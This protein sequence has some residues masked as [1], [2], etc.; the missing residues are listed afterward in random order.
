[1]HGS[2]KPAELALP[3]ASLTALRRSLAASV[4][5]D[6]AARALQ[7]AGVA[8]G[9][10]LFRVLAQGPVPASSET[11][12]PAD[13]SEQTF[14]RRFTELFERRGWGRLT[15]HALHP[16]VSALDSTDWVEVDSDAGARRPSCHFTSGMLANLLGR[17]SGEDVAVLEVE[18]RS[19]GDAR[20]RFLYGS[21]AALEVV[22]GSIRDG[23]DTE[24]SL[25]ALG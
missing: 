8:A 12:P 19:R 9:D 4:G 10:A 1:M 14:W 25:A 18:C 23:H 3:V 21:P 6:D 5:A 22:Y 15:N 20:C 16:G 13:W 17:V 7:S 2:N 11:A 24:T